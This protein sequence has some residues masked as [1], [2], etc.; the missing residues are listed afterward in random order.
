[1][2][3]S[4]KW[5]S[6]TDDETYVTD[7]DLAVLLAPMFDSSANELRR[8]LRNLSKCSLTHFD[9]AIVLVEMDMAGTITHGTSQRFKLFYRG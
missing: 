7:L 4:S 6:V 1:M 3:S 9:E 5:L 8:V 2:C